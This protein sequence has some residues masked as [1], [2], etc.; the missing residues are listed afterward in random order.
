MYPMTHPVLAFENENAVKTEIFKSATQSGDF[1]IRIFIVYVLTE[2]FENV[3]YRSSVF[4]LFSF[5]YV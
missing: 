5:V 2:V 4:D 1:G 3:A